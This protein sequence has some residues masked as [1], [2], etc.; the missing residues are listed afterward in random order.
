MILYEI[1]IYLLKYCPYIIY[2]ISICVISPLQRFCLMFT[3]FIMGTHVRIESLKRIHE[4]DKAVNATFLTAIKEFLATAKGKATVVYRLSIAWGFN[5]IFVL[6]MLQAFFSYFQGDGFTF[7]EDALPTNSFQNLYNGYDFTDID[8]T[9][10]SFGDD[11]V[12]EMKEKKEIRN[13]GFVN[14]LSSFVITTIVVV[15]CAIAIWG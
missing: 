12:V 2:E 6:G 13:N 14:S 3:C 9:Y 1:I 15:S 8:K 5:H 7:P 11:F 10:R 4:L